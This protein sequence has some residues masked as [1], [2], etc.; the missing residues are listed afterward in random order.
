MG[1]SHSLAPQKDMG[2]FLQTVFVPLVSAIFTALSEPLEE[3]EEEEKR[4][5]RLLQRGYYLFLTT[6]VS[7]NLL[8]TLAALDSSTLHQV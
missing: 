4:S 1:H 6:I 7:N 8:D 2:P 3:N 5:R